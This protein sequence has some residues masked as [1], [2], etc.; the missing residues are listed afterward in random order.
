MSTLESVDQLPDGINGLSSEFLLGLYEQWKQNPDSVNQQWQWFF[1]G[2]DLAADRP[3]TA[4][5]P[6]PQPPGHADGR[7]PS[8]VPPDLQISELVHSHRELG[9]LIAN[10]D[11]LGHNQS[12]HPLLELDEFDLSETDLDRMVKADGLGGISGTVPLRQLISMLH[13]TYCS[14]FAVEFMDIRDHAQLTFLL[15]LMEP[16]LNQP[17]LSTED[18]KYIVSRLIAAEEFEQFLQRRHP[19]TKRFS[20]EGA[21]ALIP[22]MDELIEHGASLGMD[23]AIIGMAHRGRLN[24]LAHIMRKPYEMIMAEVLDRP[25]KFTGDGDVKYHLGYACDFQTR[26][27]KPVHLSLAAN[28][29][30]LEIVDPVVEGIVRAKQNR[31]GDATRQ[32]VVPI[33]IHGDAAFT[34]EGI[35]AE[36][37]YLSELEAY[38]TGG[39]IHIIVNNQI[40]F[41]TDPHDARFTRYPSDVARAIQAPVFH[42]NGDDPEA[43]VHAARLAMAFRQRFKAD[44]IID[45]VCYRRRGHNEIDDPTITQP[46]M[47]HQIEKHPTVRQI[48]AARLLDAGHIAQPE[49]DAM[50]AD[51]RQRL[52][53][54]QEYAQT[55][56]PTDLPPPPHGPWKDLLKAPREIKDWSADTGVDKAR[57]VAMA[58]TL[59]RVPEGFSMHP[60]V[61][62]MYAHRLDCVKKGADID[63]GCGEMLAI[64]S[65]LDE[66]TWVRLTG[67]DV[68][69]G[70][71]GH[72]NAGVYDLQTGKP[73]V[74]LAAYAE[75]KSRFTLI[76]TMLSELAVV[77]FEYGFASADPHAL[78]MW[79]AQF[80]DF[81]N[82]CQPMIDQ[83][84][85]SAETKWGKYNGLV[86]LL[87][88]G[89]EGAG[90]EHSH[91]RLER[92]LQLAAEDN[93][94]VCNP[95]TPAQYFHLLRRQMHRSFRKPLIVMAPKSL[96]RHKLAVSTLDDFTHGGFQEIIDEVA[97]LDRQRVRRVLLCSGKIYYELLAERTKNNITDIAILRLEQI[98]P[99]H[100]D[101]LT[102]VASGYPRGVEIIWVQEEPRNNGVYPFIGAKMHYYWPGMQKLLYLGRKPSASPAAGSHERHVVE[103]QEIVSKALGLVPWEYSRPIVERPSL[104][105]VRNSSASEVEVTEGSA[106]GK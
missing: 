80:G 52:E 14:T 90:P 49:L 40:G 42:V 96:L 47:Y 41:T 61:R 11:P 98:Y 45:M 85:A 37:L 87:P 57:L 5:A 84:V 106:M 76:N 56:K 102:Q 46:V 12:E 44:A 104:S 74:P 95:T 34:G 31:K 60:R 71:F 32:R 21:E 28:P 77:G 1:R 78:V 105:G 82:M 17:Q 70:T 75:G 93:F 2:F 27:G 68:C 18:R 3:S 64:G 33:L 7:G 55:F 23:E 9:H 62:Q 24:V 65:L 30:H 73:Y 63:W 15:E 89:Y 69:R 26:A 38:R 79:E 81:V 66:G 6:T 100:S 99:F 8:S 103:Q 19:T 86:M 58:E 22:L 13:K 48:Y 94:Q 20:V 29:S 72:R 51:V 4:A 97:P 101:R 59:C 54:A 83:Y 50:A 88:H 91:A 53:K 43:V 39:T 25:Q 16:C 67:Q 36:T 10:L 92:F 35:V